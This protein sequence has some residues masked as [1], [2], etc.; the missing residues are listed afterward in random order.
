MPAA[1][2]ECLLGK[3]TVITASTLVSYSYRLIYSLNR[4]PAGIVETLLLP[5][6][7]KLS[8]EQIE[9]TFLYFFE[10]LLSL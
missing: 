4:I 10:V 1:G 6:Q 7:T 3:F 8:I 9:L 5:K 2:M